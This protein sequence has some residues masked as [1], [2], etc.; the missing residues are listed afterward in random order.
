VEGYREHHY[1]TLGFTGNDFSI[2]CLDEDFQGIIQ[3]MERSGWNSSV[4]VLFFLRIERPG[5]LNRRVVSNEE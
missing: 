1:P 3:S 5:M 4:Q 2:R